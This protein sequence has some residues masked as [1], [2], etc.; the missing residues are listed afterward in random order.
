[1]I[2][3]TLKRDDCFYFPTTETVVVCKECFEIN[4]SYYVPDGGGVKMPQFCSS[5]ISP[6]SL[7]P[8]QIH[9]AGIHRPVLWH[10]NWFGPHV[11]PTVH[12][13]IRVCQESA[14]HS[15]SL[16][17]HQQEG[18]AVARIARDDGSSSTN[19]SSDGYD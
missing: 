19:G 7:S 1:M 12:N 4:K 5:D 13:T 15:G 9:R 6:Q 2:I 18:L 16:A 10:W 14:I 17:M 3:W 11:G 8:S